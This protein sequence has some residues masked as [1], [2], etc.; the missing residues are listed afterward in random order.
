MNY[1][2]D[3]IDTILTAEGFTNIYIDAV[4]DDPAV[5][6]SVTNGIFLISEPTAG[7]DN[8]QQNFDFAIYVRRGDPEQARIVCND[9]YLALNTFRGRDEALSSGGI[10]ITYI[11]TTTK[12]SF[13]GN[14]T[15]AMFTEFI[16][17]FTMQY[18]DV[19]ITLM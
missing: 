7:R 3:A 5:N 13:Y 11:Q 2:L 9:V 14:N 15:Q 1:P 16:A 12:P 19:D 4:F 18:V 8:Y 17:R 10:K 6:S